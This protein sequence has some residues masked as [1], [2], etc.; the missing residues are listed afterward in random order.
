M[1]RVVSPFLTST[2]A[3]ERAVPDEPT[4]SRQPAFSKRATMPCTCSRAASC[5]CL[6]DLLSTRPSGK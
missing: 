4:A 5:A 1:P 3:I 6:S 2:S